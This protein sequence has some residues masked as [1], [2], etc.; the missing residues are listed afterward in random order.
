MNL[1]K[2]LVN[3]IKNIWLGILLSNFSLSIS[4]VKFLEC[5][6]YQTW[7]ILRAEQVHTTWIKFLY[8]AQTLSH[9]PTSLFHA[10]FFNL[11]LTRCRRQLWG[12]LQIHNPRRDCMLKGAGTSDR[13]GLRF[14]DSRSNDILW[15]WSQGRYF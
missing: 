11:I 5:I 15:H 7:Y 3:S 8:H 13:V 12:Q 4:L 2:Y 9:Y 10:T 1:A 14:G 6:S